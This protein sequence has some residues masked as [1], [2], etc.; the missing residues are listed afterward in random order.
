MP[1]SSPHTIVHPT[2]ASTKRTLLP[3]ISKLQRF[4]DLIFR[5]L[6]RGSAILVIGLMVL[7][8]VVLCY[9]SIPSFKQF[10]WRFLVDTEWDPQ[11]RLG[12]LPFI[13]G[14]LVTSLI[15]MLI[16][17]PLGVGTAAYLAE[18]APGY[19]RR[20]GSFLV[21]LLAA[22]PSVVYGF[23]GFFF[24][25]PVV[26][27][28][29]NWLGHTDSTGNGLLCAGLILSIMILPYITAI[30]FDVC[31]AVPRSQREGSL[32]LG[33]TRWQMI[34]TVVLPY[35]RPGIIGGC[36]LALGRAL[37]ETMAVMM[38]IGNKNE[39]S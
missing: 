10:G 29:F 34:W 17:I 26:L 30:T 4:Y 8:F 37:G 11:G 16:A 38:L 5:G 32:A 20:V 19:V 12:A 35:A 28:L 3:P 21:E 27:A 9:E 1:S 2:A 6:C 36:F 33:S 39:I 23:W 25:R 14:T 13:Y 22:I 15:G 7:L 31:R 18:I 24:L